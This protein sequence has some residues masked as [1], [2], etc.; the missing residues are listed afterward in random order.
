MSG[1]FLPCTL[2]INY[3]CTVLVCFYHFMIMHVLTGNFRLDNVVQRIP[4][5]VRMLQLRLIVLKSVITITINLA[6]P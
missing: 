6:V 4:H 1:E 2:K 5:V 3:R